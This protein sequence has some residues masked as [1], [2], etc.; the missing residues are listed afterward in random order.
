MIIEWWTALQISIFLSLRSKLVFRKKIFPDNIK[1]NKAVIHIE[2][3]H[4]FEDIDIS[5]NDINE[6]NDNIASAIRETRKS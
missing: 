3:K 2:L 1:A 6:V 4:G 5:E